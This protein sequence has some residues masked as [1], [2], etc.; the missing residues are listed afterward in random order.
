[1]I[2]LDTSFLYALVDQRDELHD[3]VAAWYESND[4][5]FVTTPLVVAECDHLLDRWA[6]AD[7]LEAFRNDLES[8]VFSVIWWAGAE[9]VCVQT[10]RNQGDPSVGLTDASLVAL[11]DHVGTTRIAT[12]D[13]RH[14]RSLKPLSGGSAFTL[15]PAEASR[16][17]TV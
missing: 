2:V 13:E 6:G 15:L 11:A 16:G 1:M 4:P 7:A 17:R 12:L 8:G 10:L 3:V 5:A 9:G 14:F